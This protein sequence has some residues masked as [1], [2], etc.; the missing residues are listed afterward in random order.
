MGF[1]RT[2]G[3]IKTLSAQRAITADQLLDM[4]V[5]VALDVRD[6]NGI[7]SIAD[8][9][10]SE[11]AEQV[12]NLV[13][14]YYSLTDMLLRLWN[15]NKSRIREHDAEVLDDM[16]ETENELQE[17]QPQISEVNRQID[18][19][20]AK[21]SEL[22]KQYEE[23]YA[24]RGALLDVEKK[25]EEIQGQIDKL[26]D[27]VLDTM[28][29]KRVDL[30]KELGERRA[31]ADRIEGECAAVRRETEECEERVNGLKKT[32]TELNGQKG[33]LL[34]EEASLL[35]EK[36]KAE[37]EN[38]EIR[39]KLAE[40]E[41]FLAELPE[42]NKEL[43]ASYESRKAEMTVLLNALNSA[44]SEEFLMDTLFRIPE[45]PKRLAVESYPDCGVE[46]L[47]ID[48]PK[49]L[50]N[51]CE[52]VEKRVDGLLKVY[53]TMLEVLAKQSESILKE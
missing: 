2:Q 42:K 47:E 31:V 7:K 24:V 21:K 30:E 37:S 14:C 48:S 46:A 20:K 52:S 29:Q 3:S 28:E 27:P 22:D 4:M 9:P 32:M 34:A 53:A 49:T 8:I 18:E 35:Q 36:E 51:W 10:V 6:Y 5:N 41:T 25:C 50:A 43:E 11:D 23:L 44:L 26:S 19:A 15:Q 1:D 45:M 17:I 12:E 39:I 13:D 33:D 38:A 16:K 40:Y